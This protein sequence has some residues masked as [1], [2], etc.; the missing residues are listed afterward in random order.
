MAGL[1]VPS[2]S[3]T[4][5]LISERES[6]TLE[7]LV[8]LPVRISQIL[9]AK[10]LAIVFLSSLVTLP[11][12]LVDLFWVL[13]RTTMPWGSRLLLFPVLVSAIAMST[14]S[15]LLIGLLARDFRTANNV[16]GALLAPLLV[17]SLPLAIFS[18]ST[19]FACV[20]LS[21]FYAI[22]AVVCA[23]VAIKGVTFER[24]LR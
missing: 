3:A 1:I 15:A 7:L 23:A 5:T 14:A 6:R 16:N 20:A 21:V 4:Y 10:L 22:G 19:A 11:L 8:A 17:V 13:G 12:F 9:A 18:P 2:V 24:L